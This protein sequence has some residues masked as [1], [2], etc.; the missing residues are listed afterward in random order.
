MKSKAVGCG[1]LDAPQNNRTGRCYYHAATRILSLIVSL[2]MLF[3]IT[4]GIDLSVFAQTPISGKCGANVNYYF[5][6]TSGTLTIS[7]TGKMYDYDLS[8]DYSFWDLDRELVE[9]YN[10]CIEKIII[11]SGVTTIGEYAFT[12]LWNLSNVLIPDSVTKIG[13][14]AFACCHSLK[15]IYIPDS[16]TYIGLCAFEHCESLSEIHLSKNLTE[17]PGYMLCKTNI[18]ELDIPSKVKTIYWDAF[19]G[20]KNL[21]N[22]NISNGVSTIHWEAFR[23]C[24]NLKSIILPSSVSY[25]GPD[26]FD[27]CSNLTSISIYN[28]NCDIDDRE[29]T[30]PDKAT[31]YGYRNSTA[32]QY[33]KKY[34]RKF[35]ELAEHPSQKKFNDIKNYD[36]YNDFVSYAA[37]NN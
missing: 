34:S 26:I 16:V 13:Q 35:I 4:A 14:D 8:E 22:V 9:S 1:V 25:V 30:F 28:R 19:C 7:G 18:K 37:I 24:E 21:E 36:A 29:N 23:D 33:A 5:D 20:C 27:N 12:E 17:I 10:T 15:S 32:Q 6:K 3:S 2:A 31:I 11:N